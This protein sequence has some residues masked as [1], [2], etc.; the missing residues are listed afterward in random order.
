[1]TGVDHGNVDFYGVDHGNI[2]FYGVYHG[3]V[4]FYGVD[5]LT[6]GAAVVA[7]V[8]DGVADD[9]LV[10]HFGL[11]RNLAANHNHSERE[12]QCCDNYFRRFLP[13]FGDK[14]GVVLL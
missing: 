7:D 9:A 13:I 1:L 14:F 10:V 8:L 4:D 5:R 3:N 2:D 12:R 6:L 11:G